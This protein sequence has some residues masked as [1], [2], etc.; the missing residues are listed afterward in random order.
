[1]RRHVVGD[2]NESVIDFRR[3]FKSISFDNNRCTLSG[4]SAD[5]CGNYDDRIAV[6]FD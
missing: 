5:V 4:L 6:A 1:M 2:D 3:K